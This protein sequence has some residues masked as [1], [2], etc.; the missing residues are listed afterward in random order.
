MNPKL[1]FVFVSEPG[2]PFQAPLLKFLLRYPQAT[3][4]MF[5]SDTNIAEHQW[6]RCFL[7]RSRNSSGDLLSL[8]VLL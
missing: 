1:Q 6:N 5:L 8:V 4:D 3:V 7:V 2:S